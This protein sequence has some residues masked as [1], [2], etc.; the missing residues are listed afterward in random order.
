MGLLMGLLSG[1]H[2]LRGLLRVHHPLLLLLLHGHHPLLLL[3]LLHGHHSAAGAW[4]GCSGSWAQTQGEVGSPWASW[5][6]AM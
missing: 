4:H 6:R 3:L 1:H 2:L 5:K